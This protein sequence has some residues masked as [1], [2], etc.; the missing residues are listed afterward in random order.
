MAIMP[1]LSTQSIYS[2][3]AET[4]ERRRDYPAVIYLGSRFSY[5]RVRQLAE[6]FAAALAG[7]GVTPGQKVLLFIP[8]GIR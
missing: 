2:V 6:A 5:R 4:A 1:D 3:F 7:L 8:N